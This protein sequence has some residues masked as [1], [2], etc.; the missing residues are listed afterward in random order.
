[1]AE[2]KKDAA[3]PKVR[4]PQALKRDI[5]NERKNLQ[6]RAF[7]SK[8]STAMRALQTSLSQNDEAVKRENLNTVNSL[9]DKGVNKSIFKRNKA[10]RIKARL[11]ARLHAKA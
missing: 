11:T 4:R 6:N 7:K 2:D 8:V 10:N 1:M 9:V 5:Q 3:A